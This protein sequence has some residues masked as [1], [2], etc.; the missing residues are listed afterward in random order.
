M[1]EETIHIGRAIHNKLKEQER[2]VTWFA[3][4]MNCDRTNVYKIF[5]KAHID[6]PQLLQICIILH[7]DFFAYYSAFFHDKEINV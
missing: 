2:T 7:F 3:R 1:E 6:P 5:Q 4:K